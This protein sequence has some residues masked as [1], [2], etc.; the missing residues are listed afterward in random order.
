MEDGFERYLLYCTKCRAICFLIIKSL[1]YQR[2]Q[3]WFVIY[4]FGYQLVFKITVKQKA[5][6]CPLICNS[7]TRKTSVGYSMSFYIYC[8]TYSL[9]VRD[10]GVSSR[11]IRNMFLFSW[12]EIFYPPPLLCY[13]PGAETILGGQKISSIMPLMKIFLPPLKMKSAP[14]EKNPGHAS[15]ERCVDIH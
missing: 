3:M 14:D 2:T 5:S 12:N 7:Y 8:T 13:A 15:G 1:L 10:S 9:M 6:C 11:E 4:F